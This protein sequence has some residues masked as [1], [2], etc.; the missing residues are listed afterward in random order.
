DLTIFSDVFEDAMED[1][2]MAL[3]K[4]TN[5]SNEGA[6]NEA[7]ENKLDWAWGK[8]FKLKQTARNFDDVLGVYNY[9]V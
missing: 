5:L 8:Y 1:C 9:L 3:I 7:D 2:K 6:L 4:L